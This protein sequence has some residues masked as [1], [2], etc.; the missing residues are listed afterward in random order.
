[1]P[2]KRNHPD[3]TFM[4]A[5]IVGSSGTLYHM[6]VEKMPR[7]GWDWV[8]WPSGASGQLVLA[9]LA[10]S[11]RAAAEEAEAA[12]SD[13]DRLWRDMAIASYPNSSAEP[14]GSDMVR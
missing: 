5:T 10:R 11:A 13:L 12:L 6:T 7:R 9:G 2:E 4:A 3:E 8:V 1:L 14:Y